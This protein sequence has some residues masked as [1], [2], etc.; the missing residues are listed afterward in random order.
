MLAYHNDLALLFLP[1]HWLRRSSCSPNNTT[2]LH[3]SLPQI[4]L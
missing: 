3:V 4:F 2:W 1:Q